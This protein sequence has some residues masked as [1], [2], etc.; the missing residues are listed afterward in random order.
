MGQR[1]KAGHVE[2]LSGWIK[3]RAA[4][5]GTAAFAGSNDQTIG[6]GRCIKRAGVIAFGAIGID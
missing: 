1:S 3:R 4:P 2:Y 6:S 5:I